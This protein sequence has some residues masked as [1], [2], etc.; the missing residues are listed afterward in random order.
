MSEQQCLD[1]DSQYLDDTDVGGL[2]LR[3]VLAQK[4]G[5]PLDDKIFEITLYD[6]KFMLCAFGNGSGACQGDSG[7]PAFLVENGR[8][9]DIDYRKQD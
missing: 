2:P 3:I 7:G 5:L 6:H 9:V 4:L 8:F 1:S